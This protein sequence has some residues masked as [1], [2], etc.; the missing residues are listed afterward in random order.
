MKGIIGTKLGMTQVFDANNKVVPVT[1]V[2]A[3]PCV[4]TQVRTVEKDGYQAIQLAFGAI[5]PRK[6]S[7]PEAGHFAKAGVTPRKDVAELRTSN[8]A[9]YQVGQELRA[10]VFAA[11]EIIDAS[12]ISLGKGSA[13]VM[14]RHNFS[15]FGAAHGVDRKHRTSGSI[16][17]RT[18]PGRVF[19][20]KRMMGRMGV[21]KVTVQNLSIHS[22]DPVANTILIKGAIPGAIGATVFIRSASKF[23][24]SETITKAGA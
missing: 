2:S 5:D 16:G 10:D 17:N 7:K 21:E 4:V 9:A 1:V 20:G 11:G 22:V 3:G 18:T 8:A 24:I 13:G 23:A 12:G 19:K 14:K 6:V 15:G